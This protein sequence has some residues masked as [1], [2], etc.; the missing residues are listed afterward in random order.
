MKQEKLK[1]LALSAAFGLLVSFS[2][3]AT[4]N[5]SLTVAPEDGFT[6]RNSLGNFLFLQLIL[7]ILLLMGLQ[8]H[9]Q[10]MLHKNF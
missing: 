2:N 5:L 7:L 4:V 3:A 9:T 6:L 1:I 8:M 10:W